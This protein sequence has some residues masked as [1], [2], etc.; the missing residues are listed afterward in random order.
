MAVD[1]NLKRWLANY[2]T[3]RKLKRKGMRQMSA[4]INN[5]PSVLNEAR[6]SG[7]IDDRGY[8]ERLADYQKA[9]SS[10]SKTPV[11][12]NG[13][14]LTKPNGKPLTHIEFVQQGVYKPSGDLEGVLE[15]L[16]QRQQATKKAL[17]EAPANPIVEGFKQTADLGWQSLVGGWKG[18]QNQ[19]L[20]Y[21]ALGDTRETGEVDEQGNKKKEIRPLIFGA[22]ADLLDYMPAEKLA[23]QVQMPETDTEAVGA[24]I[25]AGLVDVAFNPVNMGLLSQAGGSLSKAAAKRGIKPILGSGAVQ[26]LPVIGGIT[27]ALTKDQR[28]NIF[29]PLSA[30]L[31]WQ[32]DS[33]LK[34]RLLEA[35]SVQRQKAPMARA[36]V[37]V[38][39]NVYQAGAFGAD[40]F[41][42]GT[43]KSLK[44]GRDAIRN[45]KADQ[46]AVKTTAKQ[47][48]L[49][50]SAAATQSTKSVIKSTLDAMDASGQIPSNI[51]WALYN[52]VP[53]AAKQIA[54]QVKPYNPKT[55][56]G[57]EAP[58]AG[59]WLQVL[60][61]A[62]ILKPAENSIIAKAAG[63]ANELTAQAQSIYTAKKVYNSAVD[64]LYTDL[65]ILKTVQDRTGLNKDEAIAYL[66]LWFEKN[67]G[68]PISSYA[69][70]AVLQRITAPSKDWDP[71]SGV[72][73]EDFQKSK[74]NADEQ[75]QFAFDAQGNPSYQ[76]MGKI[77]SIWDAGLIKQ[78]QNTKRFDTDTQDAAGMPIPNKH[79]EAMHEILSKS[80]MGKYSRLTEKN[81]ARDNVK[82]IMAQMIKTAS[83]SKEDVLDEA[84]RRI[85]RLQIPEV[86]TEDENGNIRRIGLD[87]ELLFAIDIT[88]VD[89]EAALTIDATTSGMKKT[90]VDVELI[91]KTIKAFNKQLTWNDVKAGRRYSVKGFD[92]GG[93]YIMSQPI[94]SQDPSSATT[95][96][97]GREPLQKILPKGELGTR[98]LQDIETAMTTGGN[99]LQGRVPTVVLD[100]GQKRADVRDFPQSVYVNGRKFNARYLG[101]EGDFTWFQ[102]PSGAVIRQIKA[103]R[104]GAIIRDTPLA[105]LSGL[106]S[107][108]RIYG[109]SATLLDQARNT[110]PDYMDV[111]LD[112]NDS[113]SLVRIHLTDVDQK[114]IKKI[115]DKYNS[116]L[117]PEQNKP[118]PNPDKL[119]TDYEA[120]IKTYLL[121][122]NKQGSD[123]PTTNYLG[124]EQPIKVGDV[125]LIRS[126]QEGTDMKRVT[127]L[128]EESKRAVVVS[129]GKNGIGVKLAG[130]FDDPTSLI[131]SSLLV[132]ADVQRL[133]TDDVF[134]L[135][136][137]DDEALATA[138][139]FK[140]ET[141][142]QRKANEEARAADEARRLE[143]TEQQKANEFLSQIADIDEVFAAT[144][145]DKLTRVSSPEEASVILKRIQDRRRLTP[146]QY[147]DIIYT[148]L[149]NSTLDSHD[150]IVQAVLSE[151]ATDV[152]NTS[153]VIRQNEAINGLRRWLTSGE[154]D[155]IADDAADVLFSNP[156]PRTQV[157][158]E[159]SL[160]DINTVANYALRTWKSGKLETHVSNVLKNTRSYAGLTA[161]TQKPIAERVILRVKQMGSIDV[162]LSAILQRLPKQNDNAWKYVAK[163]ST[164]QQLDLLVRLTESEQFFDPK[165]EM[166]Q[167]IEAFNTAIKAI[168]GEPT[169][170]SMPAI[171]SGSYMDIVRTTVDSRTKVAQRMLV[172]SAN[173]YSQSRDPAT[174][175]S[176]SVKYFVDNLP[177]AER[178]KFVN[179][180]L[181]GLSDSAR[182]QIG[183]Y[184]TE[185]TKVSGDLSL[186]DLIEFAK[187]NKLRNLTQ[188]QNAAD[189]LARGVTAQMASIRPT[190][191]S[192]LDTDTGLASFNE[193]F[194]VLEVDPEYFGN[195][196]LQDML[197]SNREKYAQELE[198][199][200]FG[201]FMA[202]FIDDLTNVF[203]SSAF[204]PEAVSA[205]AETARNQAKKAFEV[206]TANE[207]KRMSV[208]ERIDS[209]DEAVLVESETGLG[210]ERQTA[211]TRRSDFA[212]MQEAITKLAE[213]SVDNSDAPK[214]PAT[215]SKD[216]VV[217]MRKSL[218]ETAQWLR[219][220]GNTNVSALDFILPLPGKARGG[221]A[222]LEG[223]IA[224]A[225][226]IAGDRESWKVG[227]NGEV[228]LTKFGA[229][230]RVG[231]A[232][233]FKKT[234]GMPTNAG[235]QARSLIA[236]MAEDLALLWDMNARSY[237]MRVMD[238]ELQFGNVE[239]GDF[240]ARVLQAV[241][242]S[243]TNPNDAA[244]IDQ[245]IDYVKANNT[246]L[247]FD[248]NGTPKSIVKRLFSGINGAFG[249]NLSEFLQTH[250]LAQ[251][252]NDFYTINAR[253]LSG[254]SNPTDFTVGSNIR[255]AEAFIH[256]VHPVSD[257]VSRN[258][259]NM[260]LHL[261][262]TGNAGRNAYALA[263]EV[264]HGVY[265][266][267][268]WQ[269]KYELANNALRWATNNYKPQSNSKDGAIQRAYKALKAEKATVDEA[270]KSM[271]ASDY[272]L[273]YEVDIADRDSITYSDPVINEIVVAYLTNMAL[274]SPQVFAGTD[275][276]AYSASASSA[277]RS[278]G[279][280]LGA[281]IRFMNETLDYGAVDVDRSGVIARWTLGGDSFY[282]RDD[283]GRVSHSPLE[284]GWLIR[285]AIGDE[286]ELGKFLTPLTESQGVL[287]TAG[288]LTKTNRIDIAG[289]RFASVFNRAFGKSYRDISVTIEYLVYAPPS[290]Y[291]QSVINTKLV[292][293]SP[294]RID[295]GS[296][297]QNINY[298]AIEQIVDDGVKTIYKV[299]ENG[300]VVSRPIDMNK[301]DFAYVV[302]MKDGDKTY[303]F[304]LR[305]EAL[306]GFGTRVSGYSNEAFSKQ[307]SAIIYALYGGSKRMVDALSGR[308]A[309]DDVAT[310]E[311]MMAATLNSDIV[312]DQNPL[313]GMPRGQA[314]S[315]DP[316][317][318]S[319]PNVE[320]S[321]VNARQQI[322]KD[323]ITNELEWGNA[324]I[325]GLK[326]AQGADV[327]PQ[328][329]AL[330]NTFDNLRLALFGGSA[331]GTALSGG[332]NKTN[333]TFYGRKD[334]NGYLSTPEIY[335]VGNAQSD[336]RIG[337]RQQ[338]ANELLI[339]AE[340]VN[341]DNVA[342]GLAKM[343]KAAR[344]SKGIQDFT[345]RMIGL[346]VD[347]ADLDALLQSRIIDYR[348]QGVVTPGSRTFKVIDNYAAIKELLQNNLPFGYSETINGGINGKPI[349]DYLSRL[350][351]S[352]D[353]NLANVRNQ[354]IILSHIMKRYIDLHE[355]TGVTSMTELLTKLQSPLGQDSSV[356]RD[357]VSFA[358]RLN[359]DAAFRAR[360]L[361]EWRNYELV[362]V[363][364]KRGTTPW[365]ILSEV[366][367][368][369][370]TPEQRAALATVKKPEGL[371]PF[372]AVNPD[373]GRV[374]LAER[375][376]VDG[377]WVFSDRPLSRTDISGTSL[378]KATSMISDAAG[379]R[380]N[381]SDDEKLFGAVIKTKDG[382]TYP[383]ETYVYLSPRDTDKP[384]SV[385]PK[386]FL[387]PKTNLLVGGSESL[388]TLSAA[389]K[390]TQDPKR[391]NSQIITIALPHRNEYV[392]GKV[393]MTSK[394]RNLNDILS[395]FKTAKPGELVTLRTLEVLWDA[396]EDAWRIRDRGIPFTE[397]VVQNRKLGL[398]GLLSTDKSNTAG[399]SLPEVHIA[400]ILVQKALSEN[401]PLA[402]KL[403]TISGSERKGANGKVISKG[404]TVASKMDDADETWGLTLFSNGFSQRDIEML[405][406]NPNPDDIGRLVKEAMEPDEDVDFINLIDEDPDMDPNKVEI[407]VDANGINNVRSGSKVAKALSVAA[408]GSE[409]GLNAIGQGL[410][411]VDSFVRVAKLSRDLSAMANQSYLNANWLGD[412]ISLAS[413]RRPPMMTSVALAILGM[414]PNLPSI[415]QSINNPRHALAQAG[416]TAFGDKA[417]HLAIETVLNF[418]PELSLEDMQA[419][420]LS[421][422]YLK[423]FN[424]ALTKSVRE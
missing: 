365:L 146:R 366:P 156:V 127:P 190:R 419:Y 112:P 384:H 20:K 94:G 138:R 357:F 130:R 78:I 243:A 277:F 252:T 317:D 304:L 204:R 307:S 363:A 162:G 312:D 66:N 126:Y 306:A 347:P 124:M 9:L 414:A 244:I 225:A 63:S 70:I 137:L 311:A 421:L 248:S 295:E 223:S 323:G 404:R 303:K 11:T 100:A 268:P 388:M 171:K 42:N 283:K 68:R 417:V 167:S 119:R 410:L 30:A 275:N 320:K 202:T 203:K 415:K 321:G 209:A 164:D 186:K 400:K 193:W 35:E 236:S 188:L 231:M 242:D 103:A 163:L 102:L 199:N 125:V 111:L 208:L 351:Q 38:I 16:N 43:V 81:L 206:V 362:D 422:D 278:F 60:A 132:P 407:S 113:R 274:S 249:D 222:F 420:G 247:E 288:S 282:N 276:F 290:K 245:I 151:P 80:G 377:K 367:D 338:I 361:R 270:K 360:A 21:E 343:A 159:L 39:G 291:Q 123:E 212:E 373:D 44:Q 259:V 257:D 54:S 217:A 376:P 192:D 230:N 390:D 37:N 36:G 189:A 226:R 240:Y 267:M 299:R 41:L 65:P 64:G 179:R 327:R 116:E 308:S 412:F 5:T 332:S 341:A 379:K 114:A 45:I 8:G 69:D 397:D 143:R 71:R 326:D 115:R 185:T 280:R 154:L 120:K 300:K 178:V 408:R 142:E 316:E 135:A 195:K 334:S 46:L 148:A 176:Q 296:D 79:D 364:P 356:Y 349:F 181:G 411:E 218:R 314:K 61:G 378:F 48:G 214:P 198:Q 358:Q 310:S 354:N 335:L 108:A 273:R 221:A 33:P 392:G 350:T 391:P 322:F 337:F 74:F 287:R 254:G 173:T 246:L 285:L 121:K 396:K 284:R 393:D 355:Q 238:H 330:Q 403:R 293:A 24:E 32:Q 129:V 329:I 194:D 25:G 297:I 31:A 160:S 133:S 23:E 234:L 251:L 333:A 239:A 26:S 84:N 219:Q 387:D 318:F 201:E 413:G 324:L 95:V 51:G 40:G 271:S 175:D 56:E 59:E 331:D 28:Y 255:G 402:E 345:N 57:Y 17:V 423:H 301:G 302:S 157:Q 155:V 264:T 15:S 170:K 128:R 359:A 265:H 99:P 34:S 177:E 88:D 216:D 232:Q 319:D 166:N 269:Q 144:S 107:N 49:P 3:A 279:N 97:V 261:N 352:D 424:V 286:A 298:S 289:T 394:F 281:A 147:G 109:W 374:V 228:I 22:P 220:Y 250:R 14:A 229:T 140:R 353:T 369:S 174:I 380:G 262:R 62:A 122:L 152:T 87:P 213:I 83:P 401:S 29:D 10:L 325:E 58:D 416:D 182:E 237:A 336:V 82:T 105:P 381:L 92:V 328:F 75:I 12:R 258:V 172:D 205:L 104:A 210:N 372:Y 6:K 235:D 207:A 149:R 18:I 313:G 90:S 224:D 383:I 134:N 196:D 53:T 145:A 168:A 153:S 91:P 165:S 67:V 253:L 27:S 118:A 52:I 89:A 93:V 309:Y 405:R 187:V 382:E 409:I 101:Q 315:F 200:G 294:T 342:D 399:I 73:F 266:T 55:G 117:I 110:I 371:K 241:R 191:A 215:V 292:G 406:N 180:L 375:N 263:H 1:P 344:E 183:T 340:G 47:V 136:N 395:S 386:D 19:N 72:S 96:L 50:A 305:P 227:A 348:K 169:Y 272:K 385:L 139:P 4:I 76:K 161:E 141:A 368:A 389:M 339:L 184:L 131:H 77:P 233:V 13:I 370:L 7:L 256:R 418:V 346:G 2:D 211:P 86:I 158:R 398:G 106:S 85:Q 150:H 197:L 98:I 260:V